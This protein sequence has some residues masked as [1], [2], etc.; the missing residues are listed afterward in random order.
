M[1]RVE[2]SNHYFVVCEWMAGFGASLL[3]MNGCSVW[4]LGEPESKLH[5]PGE[6]VNWFMRPA[7]GE[8]VHS[9]FFFVVSKRL[10]FDRKTRYYSS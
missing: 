1:P 3:L 5:H 8:D 9:L 6:A 4:R 7:V 2:Y 10:G